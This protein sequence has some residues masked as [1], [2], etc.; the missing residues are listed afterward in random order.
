MSVLR[1]AAMTGALLVGSV[2]VPTAAS[3]ADDNPDV[4]SS[5]SAQI[6]AWITERMSAHDLPGAAVVVVRDGEIVHLS[7]Y[8]TADPDGRPVTADTPFLIGSASKPFT[9]IVVQQLVEEGRLSLDEPVAPHLESITGEFP[10]GFDQATVGQLLNHT[11]GLS[12]DVG[13]AGTVE[14]HDPIT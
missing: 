11:G 5:G 2:L 6:D 13:L 1:R 4:T 10:K 3:A 7:G 12:M 9:A 14:I 8:G